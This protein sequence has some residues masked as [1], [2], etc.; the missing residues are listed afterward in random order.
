M[1]TILNESVAEIVKNPEELEQTE[2][3][4]DNEDIR[5]NGN[6][7][8]L[9]AKQLRERMK[10]ETTVSIY[11]KSILI[12]ANAKKYFRFMKTLLKN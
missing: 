4:S 3:E 2:T 8:R 7:N 11:T 1:R 5:N 10:T 6:N 12:C 9:T